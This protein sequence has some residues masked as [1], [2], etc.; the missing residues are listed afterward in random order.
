MATHLESTVLEQNADIGSVFSKIFTPFISRFKIQYCKAPA[1]RFVLIQCLECGCGF[2]GTYP[3]GYKEE[4]AE[5]IS[6]LA[7]FLDVKIS[8]GAT[9]V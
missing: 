7:A 8:P 6:E 1:N 2:F 4:I 3:K 9:Q 5:F